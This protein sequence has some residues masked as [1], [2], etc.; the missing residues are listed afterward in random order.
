MG[1]FNT[2]EV[3][4]AS[5]LHNTHDTLSY[6]TL[7][8]LSYAELSYAPVDPFLGLVITRKE[9]RLIKTYENSI[10]FREERK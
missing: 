4:F 5:G 6:H 8:K 1:V 3:V 10:K 7:N 2:T 9:Y